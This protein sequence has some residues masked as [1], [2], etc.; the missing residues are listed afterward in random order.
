MVKV[1]C[2]Q[3]MN[4]LRVFTNCGGKGGCFLQTELKNC[5]GKG[6]CEKIVVKNCSVTIVV[7]RVVCF[8]W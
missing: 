8:L 3:K 7:K 6:G 4:V 5:G 1:V 2:F